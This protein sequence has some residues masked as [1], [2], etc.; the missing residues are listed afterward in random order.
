MS[1]I[2]F[3]IDAETFEFEITDSEIDVSASQDYSDLSMILSDYAKKT[4]LDAYAKKTELNSKVD[5]VEG[6]TLSSNDYTNAEKS[7]LAGIEN[8]AE[9][10]VQVDWNETDSSSDAY[11]KNKP[12]ISATSDGAG[13]VTIEMV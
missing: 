10:N 5:K 8:G 11:I 6:K 1:N 13:I 3:I 12:S 2:D 4:D 9:A 7:K